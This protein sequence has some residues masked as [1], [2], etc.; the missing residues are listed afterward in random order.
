MC[1][2]IYEVLCQPNLGFQH[3]LDGFNERYV[4]I[5]YLAHN[6]SQ[7]SPLYMSSRI[8]LFRLIMLVCRA[9]SVRWYQ[10]SLRGLAM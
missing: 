5:G 9:Q 2:I 8:H 4:L 7:I 10:P 6:H 3:P 1:A